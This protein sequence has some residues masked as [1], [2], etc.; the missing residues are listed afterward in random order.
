MEWLTATLFQLLCCL[1]CVLALLWHPRTIRSAL[2]WPSTPMENAVGSLL[3]L[4]MTT[5]PDIAFS[6]SVLCCFISNP[7]QPHWRTV[8]HLFHYLQGTKDMRLTYRGDKYDPECIFTAFTDSD[9][10]GNADNGRSTSGY[11]LCIGGGA[12]SWSSRLQSLVAQSTTEAEYIASVD[13]G[14]EMVWMRHLLSEFGYSLPGP[15][16]LHMD[17]QSAISVSKNPE[18]HGRMK[19]LDL[20]FYWL[21]DQVEAGILVP[22][23]IGTNKMPADVLTKPLSRD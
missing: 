15:S 21:R 23:F 19:H 20:R 22:Q 2:R 13:A 10:A 4:A 14:R 9:H 7:G 3:F 16:V 18:H 1:D 17:N 6:V 8:Q 5:R 12:V 11:L